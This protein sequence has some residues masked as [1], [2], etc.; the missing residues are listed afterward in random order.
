MKLKLLVFNIQ[1][2]KIFIFHLKINPLRSLKH[3]NFTS[4]YLKNGFGDPTALRQ[5]DILGAITL[6]A[7][8]FSST[9]NG[10]GFQLSLT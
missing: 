9:I 4:I 7:V 8:L 10:F 5:K 1:F 3:W 6:R 2:S